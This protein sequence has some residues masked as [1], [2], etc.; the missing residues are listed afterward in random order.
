[1]QEAA[2]WCIAQSG[3]M[4][5]RSASSEEKVQWYYYIQYNICIMICVPFVCIYITCLGLNPLHDFVL[6]QAQEW[7][8]SLCS[9]FSYIHRF[10]V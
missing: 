6:L 5:T 10:V 1:M 3:N 7:H 2:F 4:R 9:P 8:H